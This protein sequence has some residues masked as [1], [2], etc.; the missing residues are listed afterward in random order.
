[1]AMVVVGIITVCLCGGSA[2]L[3]GNLESAR[4]TLGIIVGRLSINDPFFGMLCNVREYG[5]DGYP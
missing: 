3:D 4:T 1:M 2:F 5:Y